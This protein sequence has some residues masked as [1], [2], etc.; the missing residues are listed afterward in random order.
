MAGK[1]THLDDEGR[2]RMVDVGHKDVT[3]R[4]ARA[5]ATVNVGGDVARMIAE[6]G[7]VSKGNVL[8]TARLAGIQAA[9]SASRLIP[10]AHPIVLDWIDVEARVQG[11]R[12]AIASSVACAKQASLKMATFGTGSRLASVAQVGQPLSDRVLKFLEEGNSHKSPAQIGVGLRVIHR[13]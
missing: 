7:G 3:R 6:T 13:V 10:L 5:E 11:D 9:K 4:S 12:V 2:A 1:L 8:E